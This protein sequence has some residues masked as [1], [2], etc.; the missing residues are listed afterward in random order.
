MAQ[1]SIGVS[2]GYNTDLLK[3]HFVRSSCKPSMWASLSA[4]ACHTG[5]APQGFWGESKV[6]AKLKEGSKPVSVRQLPYGH[7]LFRQGKETVLLSNLFIP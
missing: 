4:S 5:V 1:Y 6:C 3:T 7:F 2:N